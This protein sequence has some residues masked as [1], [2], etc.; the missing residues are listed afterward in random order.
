MTKKFLPI[1][2]VLIFM[3]VMFSCKQNSSGDTKTNTSNNSE[4]P[5]NMDDSSSVIIDRAI[6]Y[7]G[8]YDAWQQRK[9]CRLIR[10]VSATIA[11]EKLAVS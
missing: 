2:A 11:Q 3:T 5:V 1:C 9:H 4:L 8:G 6:A 10:K 7:A